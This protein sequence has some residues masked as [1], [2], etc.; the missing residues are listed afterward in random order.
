MEA[1]CRRRGLLAG[2][3]VSF[4]D[5]A[6]GAEAGGGDHFGGGAGVPLHWDSDYDS[7]GLSGEEE[8]A[9]GL[10]EEDD[11][12]DLEGFGGPDDPESDGAPRC[13]L[14]GHATHSCW[15]KLGSPLCARCLDGLYLQRVLRTHFFPPLA[16]TAS[17]H[18]S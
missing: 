16:V 13:L 14:L 9:E 6:T 11:P 1:A 17:S 5:S 3:S 18:G 7:D 8:D 2:I 15:L 12:W 10:E 4:D